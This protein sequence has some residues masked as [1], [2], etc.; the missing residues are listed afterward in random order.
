M[1]LTTGGLW[2][3]GGYGLDLRGCL[4]VRTIW[5]RSVMVSTPAD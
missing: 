1:G 5:R 3:F 4:G 2:L